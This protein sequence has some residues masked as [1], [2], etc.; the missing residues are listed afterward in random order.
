M[1]KI[2]FYRCAACQYTEE[3]THL[4]SAC[5]SCGA[6]WLDLVYNLNEAAYAWQREL[7]HRDRNMWRY[8]ELLPLLDRHH[9]VSMGEGW[10]PLLRAENLGSM[11]G[12]RNIFIKD[13]NFT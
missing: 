13:E 5:P 11:L 4:I 8:W 3:Y 10:T 1:T 2:F 6:E 9:I 12:R 7:P